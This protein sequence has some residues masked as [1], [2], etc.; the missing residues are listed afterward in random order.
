MVR[1]SL[2]RQWVEGVESPSWWCMA[3][4]GSWPGGLDETSRL[5]LGRVAEMRQAGSNKH[6][7]GVRQG[8]SRWARLGTK[9]TC[10]SLRAHMRTAGLVRVCGKCSADW[11]RGGAALCGARM[12]ATKRDGWT[13]NL[14]AGRHMTACARTHTRQLCAR[15]AD[16]WRR[17]VKRC[18]QAAGL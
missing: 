1:T 11:A 17:L 4:V 7:A 10:A 6:W 15:V 14:C 12:R 9:W 5:G 8:G 16:G 3:D 2:A 13:V 18:E